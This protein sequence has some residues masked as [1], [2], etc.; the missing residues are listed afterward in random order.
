[1]AKIKLRFG[2]NEVE[3]DSRDFYI[4]NQT[5]HEVIESIAKHIQEK[6]TSIIFE[7]Q[8]TENPAKSTLD[9]LEDAEV[10]EPEFSDPVT[11]PATEIKNKLKILEKHSFFNTQRTVTE[12]V[13]QL[14][15]YGWHASPL[16]V[17]KALT[18]MAFNGDIFKNCETCNYKT[19]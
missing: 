8:H 2:E 12:I 7:D 4:D 16:D 19:N 14:I 9:S 18:N 17:S 5:L 15:E 6:N 1:M 11:I 10:H 3:I 13:Q